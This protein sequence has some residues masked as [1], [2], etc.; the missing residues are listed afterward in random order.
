MNKKTIQTPIR[1]SRTRHVLTCAALSALV[2]LPCF[3]VRGAAILWSAPATIAGN[4]DVS[5]T[6]TGIIAYTFGTAATVNTVTFTAVS[7]T[8][9]APGLTMSGWGTHNGTAFTSGATPFASLSTAY[10]NILVGADYLSGTGPVTLTLTGL[11]IGHN[12]AVQYWCSDPRSGIFRTNTLSSAGGNSVS[13]AENLALSDGGMGQYSVGTFTADGTAQQAFT[14]TGSGAANTQINAVQ[15][16]DLGAST[17]TVTPTF[18]LAAGMYY[19]A[20]TV[21]ILS[22][23]GATIFYTTNGANPTNTSAVYSGAI[24]LPANTSLT[25]KAYATNSAKADSAIASAAYTTVLLPAAMAPAVYGSRPGTPFLL[26]LAA[27]QIGSNRL[28]A[29]TGCRRV[30][31]STPPT[32]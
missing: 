4:T 30:C 5:T 11:T 27:A 25:L 24:T 21:T 32:V 14:I 2:I 26:Y 19:G 28:W 3:P 22:E 31:S 1:P 15:L 10:K 13:L 20:Q 29:A 8:T 16:R 12:Y 18:S 6:G 7:S 9:S 17:T 23:P